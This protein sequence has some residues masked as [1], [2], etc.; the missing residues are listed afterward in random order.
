MKSRRLLLVVVAFAVSVGLLP[1]TALAVNTPQAVIVSDNPVN[2][3]PDVLDGVVNAIV[4]I[5]DTVVVG[6]EF[7]QV[8]AAGSSTIL[9]RTNLFAF[10]ATTGTISTTFAPVLD[11]KVLALLA[12]PDGTVYAGGAFNSVNGLNR[13]KIVKLNVTTGQVVT[14]FQA[15]AGGWI[16]DIG[17]SGNRLFVGGSFT[18]IRGAPVQG[19]AALNPTT[20]VVDMSYLNFT[21][22]DPRVAGSERVQKF[23]I[24]PDGSRLVVI[25]NFTRVSGSDRK[26]IAIFDLGPT[27]A[28]LADWHTDMFPQ[29][30]PN[31]TTSW[32]S[33]TYDTYMRDVDIS[34]DGSYF[35]VGT[36]G[37]FR[38]N[39]LCDTTSRWATF[40][41]G[42]NLTPTWVSWTG[43]DSLT[44]V[45][46]TG[47]AVYV[48]GHQRWHNNPYRGDSAGPG[49]VERSGIA[50]LDPVNGMPFTWNPGRSRGKGVFALHSTPQGLWVGSDTDLFANETRR[51]IAFLPVA[52]GTTPPTVQPS[53][54]PGDLHN[55]EMAGNMVR[56]LYD[57][58]TFGPRAT[59]PTG[60]D[61]SQARG[62]FVLNDQLYMGWS[63]G[64]LYRRSF[65][66]TNVGPAAQLDLHGLE[67]QP[68][69][70]FNIPGT[71]TRIPAF[72][73]HL[74]NATGMFFDGNRIYYTVS[75]EPRL[76][77]RYFTP[78][79]EIV[80]ASLF[81]ASTSA[82]GIDWANVRGM[83]LASGQLY[84][85]S[86]LGVLSRVTFA[87]GVPSGTPTAI[88]GPAIDG[89]DWASRGMFVLGQTP[90]SDTTPPS[91]PGKPVGTS[92]SGSSIALTW[93]AS[94]DNVSSQLTYG[95][96]RDGGATPVGTVVSSSAGTVAFTDSGLAQG[97]THTYRVDATDEAGNTS[98]LSVPSDPVATPSALFAD[99]FSSGGF[100]AWTTVTRLTIDPAA[101]S[102][103]PPS[104]RGS[105]AG[106]SAFAAV[107]LASPAA[108]VCMSLALSIES[109][110]AEPVVVMRLR[111]AANGPVARVFL[112]ANRAL[113][114]K[115]DVASVQQT[116]SSGSLTPGW[117]T[118]ELCGTVGTSSTWDLLLDG[119]V[120]LNDWTANTGTSP[121]ARVEIGDTSARTWTINYDD[122]VVDSEVG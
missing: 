5:G 94:T 78:E 8:R 28:T 93:A 63:D 115:S 7:T 90:A 58:V 95:I 97:S 106:Q 52:G 20:G 53:V 108:T 68:P 101:G 29:V 3:T 88:G 30:I 15:N 89:Y 50:A 104:A 35:I 102:A 59:V 67:G 91:Q 16:H 84:L 14:A 41:T 11:Q 39:R 51:K 72:T 17:I 75:G 65:D 76:Y 42:S 2:W 48:G 45:A 86:S 99:D 54:L 105:V 74:Q 38:A 64:R 62:V 120:V 87:N 43:G 117:H 12:A 40:A 44:A 70:G 9:S 82:D 24:S 110:A 103:A 77:Y 116:S 113:V 61:W 36:T 71:T 33:Q 6:G 100:G 118:V 27:S 112:N 69:F 26:Q 32:C 60:I 109:Q 79:S 73:T 10:N 23:D 111:T 114:V 96:Y 1:V 122:V 18:A 37:A 121:V 57:G 66:G 47:T 49:A 21:F 25:G 56:R 98:P 46:V 34:P 22:T 4:Q 55:L 92:T 83:T 80:G 19:L 13:R 85:A 31:S 107:N 119:G 81:V